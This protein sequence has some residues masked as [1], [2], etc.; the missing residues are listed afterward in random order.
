MTA[1]ADSRQESTPPAAP[2]AAPAP[3]SQVEW[4]DRPSIWVRIPTWISLSGFILVLFALWYLLS[5]LDIVSPFILPHPLDVVDALGQM[6]SDMSTGGPL[7]EALGITV[8]ESVLAFLVAVVLGL[9]FGF[10][11]AESD[12]G[13]IVMMPLLVAVNAA[14]KIVFAPI[15]IAALG[16]GI[17]S[18]VALGAFIA[19][20]PLLVDTAAG[21]AS[22]DRDKAT[23]FKS[24]RISRRKTF[25]KLQL[26]SALPFIFAGLKTASVLAVIGVVVGEFIGGGGGLGQQTKI[27]GDLLATDRVYAYGIVLAVF[28]YLFYSVVEYAERKIVFWQTPHGLQAGG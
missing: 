9:G 25:F 26:P 6:A 7:A 4:G 3:E 24:L 5:S 10:L 8:L 18:K 21:M 19:F 11:V 14:P 27:A 22:V 12:F 1:P 23:L 15:F 2:P 13:R 28:G 17:S 16:F 20:F